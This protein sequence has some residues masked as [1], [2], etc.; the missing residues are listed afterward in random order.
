MKKLF[1][2]LAAAALTLGSCDKEYTNPSAATEAQVLTSADGLIAVCNSLAVRYST[3]GAQSLL[4]NAVAAGG[5]T[6]R[7]Q[8]VINQGNADEQ[9]LSQGAG[10]VTN[11]NAVVRNLWNQAQLIRANADLVLQNAGNATDP[12][13]RSGIIGFASVFRALALGNLAQFFEQAPLTTQINSPFVPRV[14]L[15]QSAVGQLETAEAALLAN[16]PSSDF[17][18][19]ITPGVDLLNTVR[20]L[21]ARYSLLAGDYDKALAAAGRVD[22]TR[23]SVLTFDE[24][25]RNAVFEW[26]YGNRNV[27]EPTDVNLGLPAALA[28]EAGDRRIPFY[29]RLTPTST[30]NRGLGFYSASTAPVPLYLPGEMLLIR[31]EAYARKN[32]LPNA[33]TELNRVRTSTAAAT[34]VNNLPTAPPGAGLAAYAGAQTQDAILLDIY[35]QRQV[36]L[37][38]QGFRLEDS[39]RFGRPGPGT[40]GAERNRNFLPYPRGE[41]E[42]NTST[43]ADPAI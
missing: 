35:R 30:Q 36:E 32:D 29:V 6:T 34:V 8:L 15:L 13:T 38:F 26:A 43:P 27:I 39:R 1:L 10:N 37:A 31:A 12:A 2:L 19:K 11:S 21:I 41:R 40:T 18:G 20:A 25:T 3:G 7:E 4:Y 5:L 42:N 9:N 14:Q 24:V 23:R 33:V 17:N 28:P 16:P 22:L